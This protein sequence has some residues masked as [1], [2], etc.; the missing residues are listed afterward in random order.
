MNLK[1]FILGLLL[2]FGVAWTAV[3]AIPYAKMN[4]VEPIEFD[5]FKDDQ[6]GVYQ[7]KTEGR[8]KDGAI[9]YKQNG[10]YLC[11]TQVIRPTYAGSEVWRNDGWAGSLKPERGDTRR[12]ST[13]FDYLEEDF[14][15]IGITRNG[16]DLSNFGNRV[17]EYAQDDSISPQ[18]WIYE[19][20]YNPRSEPMMHWSICPSQPQMFT[21]KPL[22]G[23]VPFDAV[24]V[25]PDGKAFAQPNE[26][27]RALTSYLLSFKRDDKIPQAIDYA[28]STTSQD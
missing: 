26:D 15:N 14:V 25:S 9:V 23:Q 16:P 7:H 27:A 2:T 3:I 22:Y 5:E 17:L 10:C 1:S 18:K 28:P 13:I 12:E 6:V 4:S 19:H 21:E 8:I 11:H 24:A 20:L